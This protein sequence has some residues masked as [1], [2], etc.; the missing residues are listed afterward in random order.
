MC[1]RWF[2]A[3]RV[4]RFAKALRLSSSNIRPELQL[5]GRGTAGGAIT[6]SPNRLLTT[7]A[8]QNCLAHRHRYYQRYT[9]DAN[10]TL[11][12]QFAVR[13]MCCGRRKMYPIAI[14][15]TASAGCRTVGLWTPTD[16][17]DVV[18]YYTVSRRDSPDVGLRRSHYAQ[19]A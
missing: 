11:G 19:G 7:S 8:L 15:L 17:L 4:C 1:C 6:R 2:V 3:I 9:V 14:R 10:N 5:A 12:D 13:A 16:A 18:W